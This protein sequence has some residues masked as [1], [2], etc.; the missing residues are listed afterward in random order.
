[1]KIIVFSL[2]LVIV[3][4][5]KIFKNLLKYVLQNSELFLIFKIIFHHQKAL[6]S[7]RFFFL[8]RISDKETNFHKIYFL[9]YA[10]L[11]SC[12]KNL[13]RYLT[14]IDLG[15]TTQQTIYSSDGFRRGRFLHDDLT[16]FLM[17]RIENTFTWRQ[18]IWR[19]FRRKTGHSHTL[20]F[21]LLQTS[22]S[23]NQWLSRVYYKVKQKVIVILKLKKLHHKL[24]IFFLW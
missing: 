8:W 3:R 19:V 11:V 13:E 21:Q 16:S 18:E 14:W 24:Q 12:T 2:N 1:M 23:T 7:Y 9:I 17:I 4:P 10:Y 15:S 5:T 20:V 22:N 6:E